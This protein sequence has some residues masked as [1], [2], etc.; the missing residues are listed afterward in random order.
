MRATLTAKYQL[1]NTKRTSPMEF[2]MYWL[3]INQ[4]KSGVGNFS[5]KNRC[6]NLQCF[7]PQKLHLLVGIPERF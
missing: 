3:V 5:S 7:D 6:Q 4:P 2:A 1:K